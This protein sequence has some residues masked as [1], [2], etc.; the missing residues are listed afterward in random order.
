VP[1]PFDVAADDLRLAGAIVDVDA[2]T[3][4]ATRRG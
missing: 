4:K 1:S 2:E 3:G